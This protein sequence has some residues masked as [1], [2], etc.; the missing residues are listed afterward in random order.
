[1]LYKYP[2]VE[3]PYARRPVFGDTG[4]FQTDPYW[5]DHILLYEYFN[6]DTGRV[7]EPAIKQV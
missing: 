7:L 6:G 3:Y 4:Y 2:Q 1:M 5:R